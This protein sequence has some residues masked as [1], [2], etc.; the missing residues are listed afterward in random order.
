MSTH[1]I[2]AVQANRMA[3]A[4]QGK[5]EEVCQALVNKLVEDGYS[6]DP[7]SAGS[8]F[9]PDQITWSIFDENDDEV[10]TIFGR[11]QSES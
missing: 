6:A 9:A 10:V 11:K 8:K 3:R 2:S 4:I 5:P 7:P 1:K